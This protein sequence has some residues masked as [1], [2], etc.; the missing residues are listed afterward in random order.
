MSVRCK[1][2]WKSLCNWDNLCVVAHSITSVH[3]AEKLENKNRNS[4]KYNFYSIKTHK[5]EK[6]GNRIFEFFSL[7]ADDLSVLYIFVI[8]FAHTCG[9]AAENGSVPKSVQCELWM[10]ILPRN[11]WS[12]IR[13]ISTSNVQVANLN[14]KTPTRI[15]ITS[16]AEEPHES[17]RRE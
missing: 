14:E 6:G 10:R 16:S 2:Q 13:C 4:K 15:K 17:F 7:H 12:C 5:R 1:N 9:H 8:Q 3:E 11:A